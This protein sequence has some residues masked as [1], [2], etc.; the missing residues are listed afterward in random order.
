MED[1]CKYSNLRGMKSILD[2]RGETQSRRKSAV[3]HFWL[4]N[5]FEFNSMISAGAHIH[6]HQN[7][8]KKQDSFEMPPKDETQKLAKPERNRRN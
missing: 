3:Y 7:N 1:I 8:N 6:I 2:E 4:M 5:S